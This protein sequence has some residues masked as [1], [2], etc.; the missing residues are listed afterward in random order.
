MKIK[1]FQ[2]AIL[3]VSVVIIVLILVQLYW[4]NNALQVQRMQFENNVNEALHLVVNKLEKKA[5]AAK[6]TR[7]LN[8]RK[9]PG[10]L[11]SNNNLKQTDFD[12]NF[13]L[14]NKKDLFRLNIFEEITT[15]SNGI[16]KTQTKEKYI[17]GLDTGGSLN[18]TLNDYRLPGVFNFPGNDTDKPSI[19]EL[20]KK[21]EF[22]NNIFD[23][24]VS[25]NVYND[26]LE[27]LDTT[28]VDS[29]IKAELQDQNI[30]LPYH[31]G[32]LKFNRHEFVY[33]VKKEIS[34]SIMHSKYK[35]NLSLN[36]V[37]V[38]PHVI[39]LYFPDE[40][41]FLLKSSWFML[42]GS[43]VLI[44]TIIGGYFYTFS[45]IFEQKRL[46]EI[47][48][49]FVNNMTHEFKTP[50]STISLACDVLS[51]K[52]ISKN[53]AKLEK[54]VKIIGDENKR[55]SFL[56]ESILQTA[57]LEKGKIILSFEKLDINQLIQ[58]SLNNLKLQLEKKNANISFIPEQKHSIIN[59]DK[60]HLLNVFNNLLDNAIKYSFAN[61]QL[62]IE[63]TVNSI[64]EGIIVSV[65]DN[66]IGISKDDQKRV[67][68]KLYRVPKGNL[69]DVKGFGL[70]LNYVKNI[71]EKHQGSIDLKSELNIGSEFRL[72]LPF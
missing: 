56:V 5:T 72:F 29:L 20:S 34:E 44:L 39:A 62:Q 71:V 60:I 18:F 16:L 48:N 22:V 19:N 46:S 37:F 41:N 9:Q 32:I 66:G 69:H 43:L 50:I 24:L 45:T 23:E 64:N 65:K 57:A 11:S 68:E 53:E 12:K 61:R 10:K 28:M 6:I 26:Y 51:D 33:P 54:F 49:D 35:V 1:Q 31:F 2:V 4:I 25:V 15:D 70:G 17:T 52:G 59:G 58:A 67:F 13:D 3:L 27:K 42:I 40:Q 30:T 7:R 38:E 36:N 21:K 63:I 47:K 8:L 55:L 14:S